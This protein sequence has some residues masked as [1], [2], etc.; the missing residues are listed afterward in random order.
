MKVIFVGEI[1]NMY[2]LN[3]DSSWINTKFLSY[4]LAAK[5]DKKCCLYENQKGGLK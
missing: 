1:K 4:T 5:E 2:M 3:L